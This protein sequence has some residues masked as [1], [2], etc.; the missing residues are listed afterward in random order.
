[1]NELLESDVPWRCHVIDFALVTD[2]RF[3]GQAYE[4]REVWRAA[5]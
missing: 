1:M 4:G 5:T 3:R 2:E